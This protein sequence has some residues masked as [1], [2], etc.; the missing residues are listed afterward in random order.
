MGLLFTS[1]SFGVVGGI[2]LV[3]VALVVVLLVWT[4]YDNGS[5]E[6]RSRE[7]TFCSC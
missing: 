3:A 6:E 2:L 4:P 1:T 5:P 7:Y